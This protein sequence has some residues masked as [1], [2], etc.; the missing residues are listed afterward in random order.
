M[1]EELNSCISEAG[2]VKMI[3]HICK[4]WTP[5][6]SGPAR[7]FVF[8][9]RVLV[10][11]AV[12]MAVCCCQKVRFVQKCNKEQ[13]ALLVHFTALFVTALWPVD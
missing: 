4:V 3:S 6:F 5:F 9:P 10:T 7:Y 11:M 1:D 2:L 13:P 12:N 8:H